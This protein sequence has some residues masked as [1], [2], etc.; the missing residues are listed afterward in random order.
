MKCVRGGV[1][2]LLVPAIGVPLAAQAPGGRP[3]AADQRAE[4]LTMSADQAVQ[5]AI[6]HNLELLARRLDLS[7]ADARAVTAGLRPNPVFSFSADHL[8]WLGTGFSDLNGGGPTEYSWR[9]DVPVERGGKRALRIDEAGTDRAIAD[10]RL[11]DAMRLLEQ[12]VRLACAD[13]VQTSETLALAEDTLRSFQDLATLNDNRARA[14]AIAPY[15]ATRAR[16][17]MLQFRSTVSHTQL[18]LRAAANRLRHL[19]GRP[20]SATPITVADRVSTVSA[21][22]PPDL[23]SIER[24]A[25]S[26]RADLRAAR[27]TEARN[28]AELRL[29]V[30]QGKVDFTW[31]AEYRRQAGP[32]SRSNSAGLFFSAP[33]PLFNRNQGEIAR[34]GAERTQA[35]REALAVEAVV[36]ADVEQAFD[37][38]TTARALVASIE[39][40]LLDSAR[41]ARDTAAYTYRAGA[42]TLIELLDAERAW[43]D[44]MQSYYNAQADYRRAVARLNAAA[45]LQVIR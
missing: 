23:A 17:A 5:E 43:N 18:D 42:S 35:G 44:T 6:E 39:R 31:G 2:L 28:L 9:V 12:D 14:G 20:P 38:F 10:A 16:V 7:V 41:A 33:L 40:E 4:P 27:R 36:R 1:A 13:V 11:A 37:E 45:G 8:D 19:L 22:P 24:L 25:F 29:Q 3:F 30:A 21:A 34:A 15:E 32:L 26:N